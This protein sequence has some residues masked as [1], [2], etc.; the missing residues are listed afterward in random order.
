MNIVGTRLILRALED[1][2]L[3]A[4][5]SWSND[6]LV[7]RG[8]GDQ[9]FPSSLEH[10]RRW[11]ERARADERTVRLAM[12]TR[13]GVLIGYTGFWDLHWRDRRAEHAVLIGEDAAR[14][15]GYGRE[16]IALCAE[17]AFGH[18]NL[19]RLDATILENNEA[20]LRAYQACGFTIEG[21]LR[22]HAY[23]EGQRV[24]RLVLGLLAA[25]FAARQ[26]GQASRER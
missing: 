23:R 26:A 20:S 18:L 21:V 8:M 9:H 7:T 19:H 12:Q 24:N 15:Q 5:H 4:L 22:E 14:G 17:Y 13:E 10:Q 6:P 2:D 16:A 11:L 25:E 3:P 1:G